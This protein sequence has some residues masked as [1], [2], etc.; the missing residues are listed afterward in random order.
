MWPLRI[1][2]ILYLLSGL[3]CTFQYQLAA[4]Y[5]G[6]T[7]V[8]PTGAVEFLSV[9]GGIQVGLAFAALYFSF[10]PHQAQIASLFTLFISLGLLLFR[11]VSMSL[12]A[13]SPALISMAVVELFIVL[14]LMYQLK[15]SKSE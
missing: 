13:A 6:Y 10:K 7:L 15:A 8:E 12:L 4:E 1:V 9:Y 5:I 11:C 14:L 2:G 3:W